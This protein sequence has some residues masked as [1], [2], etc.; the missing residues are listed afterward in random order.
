ME[1]RVRKIILW[2]YLTHLKTTEYLPDQVEKLVSEMKQKRIRLDLY[3]Y[4]IWLSARGSY[5]SAENMEQVFEEMKLEP[6]I[7]PNWTSF[8][9]VASVYIKIG[10][11][12][13]AESPLKTLR[14]ESPGGTR[15]HIIIL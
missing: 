4:N 8:S 12:E 3:S 10:M 5:G 2:G 9:T 1:F 11:F 6:T 13:K 14:C 7:V 15:C